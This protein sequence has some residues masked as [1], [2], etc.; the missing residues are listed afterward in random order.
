VQAIQTNAAAFYVYK[1]YQ[2]NKAAEMAALLLK[3]II[4]PYILK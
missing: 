3:K 4:K 2:N 1:A